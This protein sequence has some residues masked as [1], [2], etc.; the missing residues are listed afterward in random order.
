MILCDR[1]WRL[2]I[3]QQAVAIRPVNDAEPEPFRTV[4]TGQFAVDVLLEE[5]PL[6]LGVRQPHMHPVASTGRL[7]L[8]ES[9]S[10][11][12]S[13][14]DFQPVEA[15]RQPRGGRPL[16][17]HDFQTVLRR[18]RRAGGRQNE[19][20]VVLVVKESPAA[21]VKA[22]G[23]STAQDVTHLLRV[24]SHGVT[25]LGLAELEES[26]VDTLEEVTR[27]CAGDKEDAREGDKMHGKERQETAIEGSYRGQLSKAVIEGSY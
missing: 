3:G 5:R 18:W 21:V 11:R 27:L 15:P 6:L 24:D 14:D 4:R 17:N 2:P 25:G 7:S 12:R 13:N 26:R 1:T 9:A 8:I 20:Y 16:S 19:T 22:A 23:V 10:N